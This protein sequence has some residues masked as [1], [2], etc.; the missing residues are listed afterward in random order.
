VLIFLCGP[1][2]DDRLPREKYRL[3]VVSMRDGDGECFTR[4]LHFSMLSLALV[5]CHLEP[6]TV[7]LA[8]SQM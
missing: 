5:V 3:T 4:S 2:H 6:P 8:D 1:S 7:K